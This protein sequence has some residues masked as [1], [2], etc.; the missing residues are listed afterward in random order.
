MRELTPGV[1]IDL[2]NKKQILRMFEQ[3]VHSE[4][5]FISRVSSLVSFLIV[6]RNLNPKDNIY[7]PFIKTGVLA[8]AAEKTGVSPV[9]VR[10]STHRPAGMGL[11][12]DPTQT[13]HCRKSSS[14]C[15]TVK[16]TA[17]P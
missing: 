1:C 10:K 2:V 3:G 13:R 5:H 17:A 15:G 16:S 6:W 7:K 4:K 8:A 12:K 9:E 14:K 11:V